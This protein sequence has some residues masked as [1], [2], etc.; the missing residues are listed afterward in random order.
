VPRVGITIRSASV[1]TATGL[2]LSLTAVLPAAADPVDDTSP[3]TPASVPVSG[4]PVDEAAL[5]P[6]HDQEVVWAVCTEPPLAEDDLECAE[7]EVPLDYA[8]PTGDRVTIAV[9]RAGATDPEERLGVLLTNPGGPGGTGRLLAGMLSGTSV[10]GVYDL[11]GM[12]PRGTGASSPLDCGTDYPMIVPRPTDAEITADTRAKIQYARACDAA[13][14]DRFP[15][16]TS[17]NTARDMDVLRAVLGEEQ[18]NYVGY[19]YGTYL[20]PVYGSLFPE[21]LNLSVLDSSVHPDQVWREIFLEQAPAASANV[22]RYTEWLAGHDDVY[23]LGTDP[24]GIVDLFDQTSAKL[25][26]EPREVPGI[27]VPVDG[28]LFDSLVASVAR[29]QGYWD[30]ETWLLQILITGDPFPESPVE[31]AEVPAEEEVFEMNMDLFSAVVCEAEWPDRISE[32]HVRAREYRDAHPYGTGALWATPQACTFTQ[33]QPTEPTVEL[34]RDG[35]PEALV[36]A[37]DH[38]ANTHY[39]GGPAMADQLDSSLLTVTDE[40]GHGFFLIPDPYTGELGYP[41]VNETVEAYLIG[42]EAPNDSEC[43]GIPRPDSPAPIPT[44]HVSTALVTA[45]DDPLRGAFTGPMGLGVL[46]GR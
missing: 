37:A 12:D 40:G 8:D 36:I 26:E 33:N 24:E 46:A 9:S 29:F 5:A 2:A 35:Y 11:I 27:E 30:V 3:G 28:A 17:A 10:H 18:I 20:G 25:R 41:C 21:R 15:H 43:A 19:S 6:F 34:V 4:Y 23:G 31:P 22:E 16:M 32:Y 7:F 1:A 44:D 14:G 42:G 13:E 38:D 39:A 45:V